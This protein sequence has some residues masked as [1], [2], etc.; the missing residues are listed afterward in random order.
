MEPVRLHLPGAVI[1]LIVE[2]VYS[3]DLTSARSDPD[4]AE[5]LCALLGAAEVY[6]SRRLKEMCEELLAARRECRLKTAHF[7]F[8]SDLSALV[9]NPSCFSAFD[10]FFPCFW[11]G[12]SFFAQS[13]CLFDRW[14]V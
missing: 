9:P 4:N 2:F 6:Q 5:A 1:S 11:C 14:F 12:F 13:F 3:D 7:A 8:D 10:P